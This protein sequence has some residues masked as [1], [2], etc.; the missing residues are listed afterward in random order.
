MIN[1]VRLVVSPSPAP[2]FPW[3]FWQK[4]HSV[5]GPPGM[6]NGDARV[7]GI[8]VKV[9]AVRFNGPRSTVISGP[10]ALVNTGVAAWLW[11]FQNWIRA[12]T[13]V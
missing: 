13:W 4:P 1:E 10:E 7:T 5:P 9:F 11:L 3:K 6:I 12:T 2:V 8:A